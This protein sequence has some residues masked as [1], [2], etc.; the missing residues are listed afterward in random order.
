MSNIIDAV[1][2]AL[3]TPSGITEGHLQKVLNQLLS[4][5]LDDGDL[6]FQAAHNESWVLEEGIVKAGSHDIG[7][8]AI[9]RCEHQ[10]PHFDHT[11]EP[12]LAHAVH[13]AAGFPGYHDLYMDYLNG[14]IDWCPSV[15][16]SKNDTNC[17]GTTVPLNDVMLPPGY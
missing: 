11:G 16:G 12:V 9:A 8:R 17:T 13:E 10:I 3:L 14:P 7:E 15:E 4:A 5:K 1:E 2:A 6:Y